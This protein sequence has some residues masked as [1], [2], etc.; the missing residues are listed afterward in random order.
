MR[1]HRWRLLFSVAYD[2]N[3]TY[4]VAIRLKMGKTGDIVRDSLRYH[5]D[6]VTK[7]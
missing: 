6:I 2:E 3:A 5:M 4:Q 7:G 1:Q